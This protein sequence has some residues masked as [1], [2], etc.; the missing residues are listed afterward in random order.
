MGET[1]S[2]RSA[3]LAFVGLLAVTSAPAVGQA[4]LDYRTAAPGDL[5]RA[6]KTTPREQRGALAAAMIARGQQVLPAVR[7]A[8]RSGEA[9]E[10]IF[11]CTMIAEMRDHDGVDALVVATGDADVKV[12]RRATT[13]L[14]ILAD[15]RSAPRL[16]ELVKSESDL[17]VLKTALAALGRLGQRRDVRLIEPF[18]GHAD[19]GVRVT[20][21]AAL[22]ML[23]DERGLDLVI[24]ATHAVDPA[25]QKSATYALAFFSAA[26]AGAR[27][28]AILDDP[29]GAWKSYALIALVERRL[30]TQSVG[31]QVSTLDQLAHGRS[32]TAAEWAVDRL[33]D[34]GTPDAVAVLRKVRDRAT[35]VGAMA[36][37]RVKVLEAKP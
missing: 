5:V 6:W 1:R 2:G 33:T 31:E 15:A 30:A 22:A 4:R 26:A 18:L 3:F 11:A 35:P 29:R 27:A 34:I 19:D 28:Q 25:V 16:R 17:G 10:K 12:R 13:A 23:G 7:E 21:A 9:A 32:R 14:R 20:A 37:R 24:Q 8:A 36:D